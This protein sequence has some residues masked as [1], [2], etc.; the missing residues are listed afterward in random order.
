[1]K[2]T[3][4]LSGAPGSMICQIAGL[5]MEKDYRDRFAIA[6]VAF[7]EEPNKGLTHELTGGVSVLCDTVNNIPTIRS[8]MKDGN[9]VVIDY[10]TPTAALQNIEAYTAANV[11]F[12]I[13]TTGYDRQHAFEM[14]H[15]SATSAVIAPNMSTPIV[16]V[17]CAL[18]YLAERFPGALES[19]KLSITESHQKTKKDVSGTA[20]AFV[21]FFEAMGIRPEDIQIESIRD[22]A[23][24]RALGVP[25]ENLKGHGYH[26]YNVQ[27]AAGDVALS[28]SHN[29]NGRRVY[30]E[31]T[32]RAAEF[33]AQKVADGSK[34]EVFSMEDVMAG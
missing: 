1:M 27:S 29:I 22:E 28:L 24:Q 34:G 10:T 19:Y 18:K 4:L 9:V 13:G 11:P 26:W 21:N 17:Q 7:S 3:L 25:E 12:V 30:A 20:K 16:M 5:A 31:G 23:E 2:T 33:L 14:V 6:P 8:E 15:R 32:L